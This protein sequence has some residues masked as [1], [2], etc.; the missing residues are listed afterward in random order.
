MVTIKIICTFAIAFI[1]YELYQQY[2]SNLKLGVI[3]TLR[4]TMTNC[5]LLLSL[6]DHLKLKECVPNLP[7]KDQ[8]RIDFIGLAGLEYTR[9]ARELADAFENDDRKA[10][11]NPDIYL[12]EC[13]K[14]KA[15]VLHEVAKNTLALLFNDDKKLTERFIAEFYAINRDDMVN[16][17]CLLTKTA[18]LYKKYK[19]GISND[20][21]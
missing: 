9:Q 19:E 17:A 21:A 10:G 4:R 16:N 18:E 5:I 12:M 13:Y 2:K 15:E 1:L 8:V 3:N 6:Y 14:V 20:G 11:C 7:M